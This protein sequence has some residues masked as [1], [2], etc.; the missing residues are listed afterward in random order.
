MMKK[1]MQKRKEREKLCKEATFVKK[2]YGE[3]KA[4]KQDVVDMHKQLSDFLSDNDPYWSTWNDFM[5]S[6]IWK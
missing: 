1:L 2:Q 3:E 4:R 6:N 5:K